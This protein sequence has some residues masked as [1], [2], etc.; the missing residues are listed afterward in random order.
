[1]SRT[2]ARA[3][4][5]LLLA[6]ATFAGCSWRSAGEAD[7]VAPAPSDLPLPSEGMTLG[8]AIAVVETEEQGDFS[9]SAEV[10]RIA[11]IEGGIW[12]DVPARAAR[13]SD[14]APAA[15]A[16]YVVVAQ[17]TCSDWATTRDRWSDD[18]ASWF[19]FAGGKLVAFDHWT[20]GPR[21]ALGNA[22]SPVPAGSPSVSTERDL[23]RWLEQRHPPGKIPTEL[24]FAR[25][26]AFAA[27][28]RLPE[29]R[30]ILRFSDDALDYRED[31]FEVRESTEDERSAFDAE[32]RRLRDLRADL[33]TA[34]REAEARAAGAP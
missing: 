3:T 25:G 28:D 22:F 32:S 34:I 6:S 5:L 1:M 7:A 19:L 27:A 11:K 17:R 26:R 30:A 29:A 33:S 31:V 8:E 2:F 16:E 18:R 21:C 12:E 13:R 14:F 10:L 9:V 4:A 20:F 24:R 23:L 15:G